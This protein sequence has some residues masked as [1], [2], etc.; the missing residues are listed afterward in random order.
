M[1][2]YIFAIQYKQDD[3]STNCTSGCSIPT[4]PVLSSS[5]TKAGKDDQ[6]DQE[7]AAH[8]E[9][10]KYDNVDQEQAAQHMVN[11]KKMTRRWP[12]TIVESGE[13]EKYDNVDQEP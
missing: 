6:V 3:F 11:M 5:I 1:V 7:Q 2:F 13:H 10:E 9:H 4:G 8:G 12:V